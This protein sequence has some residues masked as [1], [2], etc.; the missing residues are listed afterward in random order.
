MAGADQKSWLCCCPARKY[1][2]LHQEMGSISKSH[3]NTSHQVVVLTV[4]VLDLGQILFMSNKAQL[5][6]LRYQR[7][8]RYTVKRQA[9]V[10]RYL[11]CHAAAV[12]T[13]RC[14]YNHKAH[15][16]TQLRA[17][18]PLKLTPLNPQATTLLTRQPPLST[19]TCLQ[20]AQAQENGPAQDPACLLPCGCV[21]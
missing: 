12:C 10:S 19:P 3:T 15:T 9:H 16:T 18:Q 21:S 8:P 1:M 20:G 5:H 13:I 6:H 14:L 7:K 2:L 17:R 4:L 11:V